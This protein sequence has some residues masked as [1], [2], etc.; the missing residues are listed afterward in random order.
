MTEYLFDSW[1]NIMTTDIWYARPDF[2]KKLL[3]EQSVFID[4]PGLQTIK[5]IMSIRTEFSR[6]A[7]VCTIDVNIWDW[8]RV[9][10]PEEHKLLRL[11]PSVDLV[12]LYTWNFP[13]LKLQGT[14]SYGWWHCLGRQYWHCCKIVYGNC[15]QPF[16]NHCWCLYMWLNL[17][18]WWIRIP[19]L[20]HKLLSISRH[21]QLLLQY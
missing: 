9:F 15:G 10:W 14:P 16:R 7:S 18:A 2:A 5:D 13:S 17:L 6:R 12:W 11:H 3:N 1:L 20:S 4:S 8:F 21:P 19:K